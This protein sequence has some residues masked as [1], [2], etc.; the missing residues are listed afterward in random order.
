M[1][2]QPRPVRKPRL[3][4]SGCSCFS[5]GRIRDAFC[6]RPAASGSAINPQDDVSLGIVLG[7][8][9]VACARLLPFIELENWAGIS[10]AVGLPVSP[11]V[12]PAARWPLSVAVCMTVDFCGFPPGKWFTLSISA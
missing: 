9:L 2:D 1:V 5:L 4:G 12:F 10:L 11:L 8:D 7:S 6:S 3:Q